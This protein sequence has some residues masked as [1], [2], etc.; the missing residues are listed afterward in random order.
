MPRLLVK[1]GSPAAWEIHLKPGPNLLGRGAS[2]DFPIPD[3]S[4]SGTHCEIQVNDHTAILK[5]LGSTNGTFVDG[6]LT[7]ESELKPGQTIHL[8]SVELTY[9]SDEQSS[10]YVRQTVAARPQ[11]SA[12]ATPAVVEP[13]RTTRIPLPTGADSSPAS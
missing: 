10:P 13:P 1:P 6:T 12:E 8:G 3:D 9:L 7:A 11:F 5:D 4:V 2:N